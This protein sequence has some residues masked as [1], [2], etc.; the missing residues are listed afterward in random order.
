MI[1]LLCTVLFG[2]ELPAAGASPATGVETRPQFV[3]VLT[4]G[5]EAAP[6]LA[7]YGATKVDQWYDRIFIRISDE[8]ARELSKHPRVR[9]VQR[10]LEAGER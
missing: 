7:A 1:A 6:D 3:L 4:G 5:S 2:G 10:M 8:Q 9:F